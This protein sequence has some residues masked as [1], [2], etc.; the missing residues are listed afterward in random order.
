MVEY[1]GQFW[2][3]GQTLE[4]LGAIVNV[5]KGGLV[6]YGS[7]IGGLAGFAAYIVNK[8]FPLWATLD[9]VAPGMLLGLVLGRVGCFCSTAAASAAS[10]I[11][12]GP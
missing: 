9:L 12:L 3:P 2:I 5:T 11:C 10:A 7:L 6:V 8:K 4:T 1:S